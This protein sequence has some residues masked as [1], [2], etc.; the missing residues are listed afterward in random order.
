ME[1]GKTVFQ[2]FKNIFCLP[3]NE[4]SGREE[5]MLHPQYEKKKKGVM[6]D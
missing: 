5:E 3:A 4:W 1:Y 2:D 6:L